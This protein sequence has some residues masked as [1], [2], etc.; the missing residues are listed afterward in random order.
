LHGLCRYQQRCSRGAGGRN[1]RL[2]PHHH[3]CAASSER[4][5]LITLLLY[6]GSYIFSQTIFSM[7]G[8]VK[9]RVHGAIVSGMEMILFFLPFSVVEYMVSSRPFS[10]CDK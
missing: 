2:A 1:D 4:G 3:A 10:H 8:G 6:T 9:N 7:R 5:W